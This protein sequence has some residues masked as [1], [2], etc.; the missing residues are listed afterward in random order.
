M[1][2]DRAVLKIQ[3]MTCYSLKSLKHQSGSF[4]QTD[5]TDAIPSSQTFMF[6]GFY[7]FIFINVLS[8]NTGNVWQTKLVS[9]LVKYT[10]YKK[11][12]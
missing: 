11:T 7:V 2:R 4:C 3:N 9:S 5:F 1:K 10:K 12:V 6:I 8:L